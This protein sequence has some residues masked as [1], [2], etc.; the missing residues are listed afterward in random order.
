[1]HADLADAD[2]CPGLAE[3]AVERC[4]GLDVLVSNAGIARGAPLARSRGRLGLPCS[5]STC[6]PPG[7]SP[8]GARRARAE[9]RRDRR[10]RVD[11][12][13]RSVPR[14]RRLLA[15]QGGAGDALPAARAGVGRRRHPRQLGVARDHPHAADRADLP[16]RRAAAAPAGGRAARPHR[17]AGGR[18]ARDRPPRGP[19]RRLRH[20][21]RPAA[22]RRTRRPRARDDSRH[23]AIGGGAEGRS[24]S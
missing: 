5:P 23:A 14:A 12:G 8:R 17:H 4:G 3:E 16:R 6:A 9:P 21:H 20:R 10:G 1:M 22:R 7:C 13:A 19:R 18:G 24:A 11:L 2:A 15:G